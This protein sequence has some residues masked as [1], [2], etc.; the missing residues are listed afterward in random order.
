MLSI[1]KEVDVLD[2]LMLV[3]FMPGNEYTVDLLAHKGTVI[4]Q[5]G[6]ENVVSLMSIAQES[7]LAYD[8]Q[9]YKICSDVVRL[10]HMERQF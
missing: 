7:V 8:W 9:A 2:E 5:V 10:M 6:R 1:L 4:Y 3:E